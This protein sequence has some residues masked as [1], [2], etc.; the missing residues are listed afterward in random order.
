MLLRCAFLLFP[1]LVSAQP[2]DITTRDDP[3]SYAEPLRV[4]TQHIALDLNVDFAA[5]LLAGS[6]VL[7]IKTLDPDV[8]ELKLDTRDL[9]IKS[10]EVAKSKR[11]FEETSFTL[12]EVD[13][14][15]GQALI[16]QLPK[17]ATQ[18]RIHYAT[19]QK[20]SGLQWLTAAQTKGKKH[21]FLFTQS[22]AIHARSWIPLQDTPAVRATYSARIRTPKSLLAVMSAAN[23][24]KEA[25][26]IANSVIYGLSGSIWTKDGSKAL[27]VAKAFDT[28]ICWVNTM[29]SGYPQI[30]LSP[31][32]LSGTGVELGCLL[33]TS[34]SPRD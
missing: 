21:P 12:G 13:P 14:V 32:K 7:T 6:V 10:V 15:L 20:A 4:K 22:Q 26:A 9:A 17:R 34:P 25:V 5:R 27:R 1:A 28:G 11:G 31:H 8:R 23:D 19:T 33:Y 30:S 16:I 18:V 29:L 2:V 24:P 3:H